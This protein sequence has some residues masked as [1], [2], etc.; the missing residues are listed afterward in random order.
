MYAHGMYP[1]LPPQLRILDYTQLQISNLPVFLSNNISFNSQILILIGLLFLLLGF[2]ISSF[3]DPILM[4][5]LISPWLFEVLILH[6]FN[7]ASFYL[8]Y[9]SFAIAGSAIAAVLGIKIIFEGKSFLFN[10]LILLRRMEKEKLVFH[11]I[12]ILVLSTVFFY[13]LSIPPSFPLISGSIYRNYTQ[14]QATLSKIPPNANVMLQS[15]IYPHLY[16]IDHLEFPPNT[17][18]NESIPGGIYN[19]TLSFYW[20]KPNYVVIY[21]SKNVWF[22]SYNNDF[23]TSKFN[24]Y[25]YMG[26][27]F[28]LYNSADGVEI[29]RRN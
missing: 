16:Y 1:N 24:I 3:A 2:G 4:I 23:N 9:Y 11:L 27:N 19:A 8:D 6:N 21:P 10:K 14:I 22:A 12:I 7:F 29:Y 26:S 13:I 20:F 15:N 25:T 28:T 18:Y 5:I 17:I